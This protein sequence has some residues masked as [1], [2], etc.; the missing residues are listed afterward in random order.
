MHILSSDNRSEFLACPQ[1][2][3]LDYAKAGDSFEPTL[4]VKGSTLLLKYIL[5]RV[6]LQFIATRIDDRLL[7][8]LRVEE[9]EGKPVILWSVVEK[10][11]ELK[12]LAELVKAGQCPAFLFNELAVNVAWAEVAVVTF[13]A[14]PSSLTQQLTLGRADYSLIG[15]KASSAL[16]QLILGNSGSFLLANVSA[17]HPWKRIKNVLVT[18]QATASRIDIFS[19][20]DGIEQEQLAIWL[21]D[22]LHPDGAYHSPQ[23]PNGPRRR[24]LTD[25]LLTYPNGAFLLES[26]A[27]KLRSEGPAP[28]RQHLADAVSKHVSKAITQLQGG[29]RELKLGAVVTSAAGETIDVERSQ[30]FHAIVLVPELDLVDDEAGSINVSTVSFMKKTGAFLHLLDVAELLRMVQ[31]AEI[32]A[33]KGKQITLMMALDYY[34]L[35]RAEKAA[36][37][38]TLRFSMLLR[39]E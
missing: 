7:Y 32:V 37:A 16:D 33:S 11:E 10:P 19:L 12:A 13:Q 17:N 28:H 4:L 30:P 9:E 25:V 8:G 5:A 23:I 39:T 6:K 38:K 34:L 22:H 21:T 1:L 18:N 14:S 20:D 29:I 26:K 35:S 27:L 24:E 2:V 31:A 15:E 3:K 36:E